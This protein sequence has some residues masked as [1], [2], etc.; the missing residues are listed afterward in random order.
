VAAIVGGGAV[1]AYA[2][3]PHP[4]P[5]GYTSLALQ[6]DVRGPLTVPATGADL[7]VRV[8][9]RDRRPA[10]YRLTVELGGHP[11]GAASTVDVA[12][13][14]TRTAVV[15]VPGPPDGCLYRAVARLHPVEP[16]G[17]DLTAVIYV[18]GTGS[19]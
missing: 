7:P 2:R 6:A 17:R 14:A 3:L 11:V 13:T 4:Q 10:T 12:A 1:A 5:P 18:R 19:C 8:E 16:A 9:R 15:R